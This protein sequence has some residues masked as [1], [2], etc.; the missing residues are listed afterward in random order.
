MS[1]MTRLILTTDDS[2]AGSLRTAGRAD[3]VIPFGLRFVRGPLPIPEEL[4]TLLAARSAK[5]GSPGSHWLAFV[6]SRRLEEI[7][8]KDLALIDLCE[9]R[10]SS[11]SLP[12]R[13]HKARS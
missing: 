3:I 12:T 13:S 10:T 9:Q 8:A 5:H 7:V 11:G 4:A 1:A 6:R 2:G